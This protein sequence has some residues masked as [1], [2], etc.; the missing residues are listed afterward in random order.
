MVPNG[1]K[2]ANER[3][4]TMLPYDKNRILI[5]T[6]TQGLFLYDGKDFT[7]FKT[8]ADPYIFNTSLYGGLVLS[9]GLFALNT[10][11]NGMVI[12]DK[13]GKLIERI[14]KSMGL[15]DNSV[16][17]LFEDSRDMLWMPFLMESQN[18]IF[19]LRSPF[20]MNRWAYRLKQCFQWFHFSIPFMPAPITGFIF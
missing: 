20:L 19:I 7:P 2:F 17:Y 18:S 8:E 6:R 4:Y 3:I 15:Q 12:I 11:N 5:G 16:D 10:F 1:E 9:N 14:D 13:Q